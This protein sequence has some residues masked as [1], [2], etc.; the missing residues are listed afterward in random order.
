MGGGGGQAAGGA[1]GGGPLAQF[2][3]QFGQFGQQQGAPQMQAAPT[4]PTN[5]G[6]SGW[7]RSGPSQN[8]WNN[9][10]QPAVAAPTDA[11][12]TAAA[13][14]QAET[15]YDKARRE[16]F[17]IPDPNAPA[18]PA[19][20]APAPTPATT[21]SALP[22]GFNGDPDHDSQIIQFGPIMKGASVH[23]D[24]WRA[25]IEDKT[26]QMAKNYGMQW[27]GTTA[28]NPTPAAPTG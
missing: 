15:P 9:V 4:L 11:P 24:L 13:T 1:G 19:T 23:R 3:Q 22:V 18:A 26:G 20:P 21:A 5:P 2:M 10:G 16:Y 8:W 25:I 28:F 12:A 6:L 7:H 17:G 27:P 14:P